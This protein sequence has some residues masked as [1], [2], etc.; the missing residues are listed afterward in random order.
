MNNASNRGTYIS[1]ALCKTLATISVT[2]EVAFSRLDIEELQRLSRRSQW[3][4]ALC[5]LPKTLCK[6]EPIEFLYLK[7]SRRS[8]LMLDSDVTSHCKMWRRK[9]SS[10]CKLVSFDAS[11]FLAIANTRSPRLKSC[12]VSS[13]PI[14]RDA[15][16]ISQVVCLLVLLIVAIVRRDI[17]KS[18]I[19]S[20]TSSFWLR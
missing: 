18:R 19:G 2:C 1:V 9:S 16:T 5:G 17:G 20:T 8:T 6:S 4:L 13:S 11:I 14:P 15:P 10:S 7:K 3:S 12:V